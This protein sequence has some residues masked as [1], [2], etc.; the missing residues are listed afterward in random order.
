M[1]FPGLWHVGVKGPA[2]GRGIGESSARPNKKKWTALP[3]SRYCWLLSSRFASLEHCTAASPVFPQ[4]GE[5]QG[6]PPG[7]FSE[8]PL[9]RITGSEV[10]CPSGLFKC[11]LWEFSISCRCPAVGSAALICCCWALPQNCLVPTP[12]GGCVE[13]RVSGLA[14]TCF[15]IQVLCKSRAPLPLPQQRC[16]GGSPFSQ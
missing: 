9:G 12:G 11:H 10:A 15:E 7:E 3:W 13:P 2:N 16:G 8:E 6:L 4:R 5:A 1:Q 14:V